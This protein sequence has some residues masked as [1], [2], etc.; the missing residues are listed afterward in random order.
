M[1]FD[2]SIAP[3]FI[4]GGCK[5]R[6]SRYITDELV[7]LYTGAFGFF[8]MDPAERAKARLERKRK[9][10]ARVRLQQKMAQQFPD[11]AS[12]VGVTPADPLKVAINAGWEE[13]LQ[14]QR[15]FSDHLRFHVESLTHLLGGLQV[16][17]G[18]LDSE[19]CIRETATD[20]PRETLQVH[21]GAAVVGTMPQ[22][23]TPRWHHVDEIWSLVAVQIAAVRGGSDFG[24]YPAICR[25]ALKAAQSVMLH[26]SKG[27]VGAWMA[28]AR[29]AVKSHSVAILGCLCGLCHASAMVARQLLSPAW[30]RRFL[31]SRQREEYVVRL[32]HG[33]AVEMTFAIT[34]MS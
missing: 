4:L 19:P 28:I 34:G 33:R 26:H 2:T 32:L 11:M 21:D 23:D 30:A 18:E 1:P 12:V 25:A 10:K 14:R 7:V 27:D 31:T 24:C 5:K 6:S 13:M 20:A 17:M 22:L 16:Y 8:R 15:L 9:S 3:T 29:V